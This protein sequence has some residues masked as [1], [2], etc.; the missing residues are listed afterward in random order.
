VRSSVISFRVIQGSSGS[1]IKSEYPYRV[2]IL[3]MDDPTCPN[4]LA[5][6]HHCTRLR[7][8]ISSDNPTL[9][10]SPEYI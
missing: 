3:A 4:E 6:G 7:S 8:S 10:D 1:L 5:T 9:I 2:L